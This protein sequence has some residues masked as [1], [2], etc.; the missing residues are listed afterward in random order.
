LDHH[1]LGAIKEASMILVLAVALAG[2]IIIAA[3]ISF[4]WSMARDVG[5]AE[6]ELRRQVLQF[7]R[8]ALSAKT[9]ED[10]AA[11]VM[12]RRSQPFRQ[13]LQ[14]VGEDAR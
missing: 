13:L 14:Q 7:Y 1:R 5:D 9:A 3:L 11:L 10:D 12:H 6:E 8:V 2:G 4:C